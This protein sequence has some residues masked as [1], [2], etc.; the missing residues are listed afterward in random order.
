MQ[1][2]TFSIKSKSDLNLFFFKFFYE[3][4]FCS[5]P[6][7]VQLYKFL[8]SVGVLHVILSLSELVS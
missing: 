8:V 4:S 1:L 2:E 5:D 7:K 3:L 6:L